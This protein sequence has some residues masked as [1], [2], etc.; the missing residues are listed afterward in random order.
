MIWRYP[1]PVSEGRASPRGHV[2]L[3]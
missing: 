2:R 1:G 3:V